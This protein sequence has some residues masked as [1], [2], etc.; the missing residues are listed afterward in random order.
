M[1]F[2]AV[3][4]AISLG[5]QVNVQQYFEY[6]AENCRAA[7]ASFLKIG[8]VIFLLFTTVPSHSFHFEST[9]HHGKVCILRYDLHHLQSSVMG[10]FESKVVLSMINHNQN[11]I[12]KGE[13]NPTI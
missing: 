6:F 3:T 4:A 12:V 2:G 11:P 7:L 13:S 1:N 8:N 9:E 10:E 5:A